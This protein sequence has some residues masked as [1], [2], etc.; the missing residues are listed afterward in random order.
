MPNKK[1]FRFGV[2]TESAPSREQWIALV[3]KTESLGYATF[4]L[5]DHFVNE[6][7][8]LVALMA[9]ADAT[10]TLRVG[11][12]VFD[13]DFRHP[14]LLAKEVATLDLLSG[15]RFELGM[16]A[17]WHRPEYE[18][19]GLT[20]DRAGVRISRMEE[21]LKVIKQ[22]FTQESVT[23]AGTHYTVT[24]LKAFPKP[25]Q[26]PHP[27][28]LVGGGGKRLLTV[29]GQEADIISLH[30]RVKDDGTVDASEYTD[31]GMAQKVEWVRQAAG[32]RFEDLEL[33]LLINRLI[34]T[35]DPQQAAE[36]YI[37][38]RGQSGVTAEQ[39]LASPYM[40]VG[41]IEQIIEKIQRLREQFGISY[42]VLDADYMEEFAPIVSR[43]A[44]SS[45]NEAI[46]QTWPDEA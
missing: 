14:A 17:G 5:A 29:A 40:F 45:P 30:L 16:G 10:K 24:N 26:R 39:F 11:T 32:E 19:A 43:L 46:E 21:A 33:N 28:I 27:P 44:G 42:F 23:F 6:F 8:P 2:I 41:S 18:Q 20:F 25:H 36:Q 35:Q 31:A 7:P 3:Q 12:F 4:L 34:I 22:F 37:R 13:N 15:G 38:E 1:P 9:A